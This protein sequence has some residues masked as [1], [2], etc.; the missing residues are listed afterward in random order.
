MTER[1]KEPR[2]PTYLGARIVHSRRDWAT[3]CVVRN[4]SPTGARLDLMQDTLVPEEFSLRIPWQKIELR[5]RTRWRRDWQVGVEA[6]AET[7]PAPIDFEVERRM[8]DVEAGTA[9][10][11]RRLAD[12]TEGSV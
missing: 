3:N 11:K 5:V 9:A 7:L 10:L 2:W 1:R 6:T 8:R 12:L 4:L